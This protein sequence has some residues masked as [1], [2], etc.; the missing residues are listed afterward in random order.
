MSSVL[1]CFRIFFWSDELIFGEENRFYAAH[2]DAY[3]APG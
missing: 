1:D 3:V 2:I